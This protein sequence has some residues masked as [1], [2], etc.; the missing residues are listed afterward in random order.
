MKSDSFVVETV[1]DPTVLQPRTP[2]VIS[3]TAKPQTTH[4]VSASPS[5]SSSSITTAPRVQVIILLPP[6][7]MVAIYAPLVLVAPLHDMPQDY[8]MN[9]SHICSFGVGCT[10]P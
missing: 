5:S 9:G 2:E 3:P 8:Q 10:S 1:L 4:Y 6:P 7:I